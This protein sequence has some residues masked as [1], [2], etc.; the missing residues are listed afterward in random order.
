M[1]RLYIITGANGH[2]AGTIIRYLKK[3]DCMIRGLILPSE[4]ADDE[5]SIKY[6]KGDITKI[7][8]MEEIF[9]DTD[10]YEVIVMHV[11]GL[12]SIASNVSPLIYDVNVNGTKNVISLCMKYNVKRMIYVSSVHA[13]PE[14]EGM[15]IISEV[16]SFS[17]DWV[18]GAY[19]RTKAE[20]SQAVVDAVK[21]GLDAV[22]VH[23]SGI[24]GPYDEGNN[25][26]VQL[27]K[28]YISGKLPAGITGGYDF[29]DVR[30]VAKG[31]IAA[32]DLGDKGECYILSNRY[33]PVKDML[34]YMRIATNGKRKMCLPLSLAACA[35]PVSEWIGKVT[36]TRPLFTVYSL[37]TMRSNSRFSHDK[38]TMQLAYSPRDMKVTVADTISW[39]KTKKCS[40]F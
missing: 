17:K 3:E 6:Y 37:H 7:E 27:I 28:S 4:K 35:A 29:V 11:A 16:T 30:D 24:L 33:V 15:G 32:V 39:L 1:Q 21:E 25:H 18:E 20:A 14:V 26:M 5:K 19:A 34:E 36:K 12:I 40:E 8:T 10:G 38:A 2:L 9:S 31:C 22:L 13:I 23:P